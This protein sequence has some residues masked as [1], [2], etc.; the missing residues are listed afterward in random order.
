M[1]LGN[2]NGTDGQT[3]RRTDRVR[4]NMRPP[5]R[6]EGRIINKSMN[7]CVPKIYISVI[8]VSFSCFFSSFY[9]IHCYFFLPWLHYI[10]SVAVVITLFI[11]KFRQISYT[12]ITG[13]TSAKSQSVNIGL[14]SGFLRFYSGLNSYFFASKIRPSIN[15]IY[16]HGVT[17]RRNFWTPYLSPNGLT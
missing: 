8:C 6:E 15:L 1:T 3:D 4:R 10:I 2:D 5:P 14:K 16:F 7:K 13:P 12:C 11:F 17:L 9:S